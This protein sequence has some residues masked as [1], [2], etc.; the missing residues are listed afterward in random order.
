LEVVNPNLIAKKSRRLKQAKQTGFE[1]VKKSDLNQAWKLK[2]Q[3]IGAT[4][5]FCIIIR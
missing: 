4:N 1:S 2:I 5:F 3:L